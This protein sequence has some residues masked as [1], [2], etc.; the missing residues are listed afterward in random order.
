MRPLIPALSVNTKETNASYKELFGGYTDNARNLRYWDIRYMQLGDAATLSGATN[1]LFDRG[2]LWEGLF[3]LDLATGYLYTFFNENRFEQ[4]L[5]SSKFSKHYLGSLLILNSKLDSIGK[6]QLDLLDNEQE[7]KMRVKDCNDLLKQHVKEVK[8][9]IPITFTLK[10]GEVVRA[11]EYLLN[12]YGDVITA[13]D[14]SNLILPEMNQVEINNETQEYGKPIVKLNEK[15]MK[16]VEKKME[17]I[18]KIKQDP[19]R[20]NNDNINKGLDN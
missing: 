15:Q 5:Q 2:P 4:V 17:G 18:A 7:R 3:T 8:V 9:V 16:K 13:N 12:S 1:I 20:S 10:G 11:R 6:H 14:I 19:K